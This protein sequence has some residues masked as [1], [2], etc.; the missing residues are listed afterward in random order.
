MIQDCIK[1]DLSEQAW[2][3][4][5][6]PSVGSGGIVRETLAQ[7]GCLSR[8]EPERMKYDV[9]GLA[10]PITFCPINSPFKLSNSIPR[11]ASRSLHPRAYLS[12]PLAPCPS[13][14]PKKAS[15]CWL[16][17]RDGG[18]RIIFTFGANFRSG[19]HMHGGDCCEGAR[20]GEKLGACSF[21]ATRCSESSFGALCLSVP[22]RKQRRSDLAVCVSVSGSPSLFFFVPCVTPLTRLAPNQICVIS[23]LVPQTGGERQERHVNIC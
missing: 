21:L 15:S 6:M 4:A 19:L 17:G 8:R 12:T 3:L 23:D 11:T 1:L 18:V 5:P 9:F 22:S 20:K 10:S 16:L 14:H 13:S 7:P 2:S